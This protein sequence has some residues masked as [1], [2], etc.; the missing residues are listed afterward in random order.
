MAEREAAEKAAKEK[1]AK[2]A[3]AEKA[4]AVKA[5]AETAAAETLAAETAA[6]ETAAAEKAAAEKA[7]AEKAVAGLEKTDAAAA[8]QEANIIDEAPGTTYAIGRFNFTDMWFVVTELKRLD[9]GPLKPGI[10]VKFV[11]RLDGTKLSAVLPSPRCDWVFETTSA[12]PK[13]ENA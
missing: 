5:A 7:A 13:D 2:A 12:K 10:K 3:A 11:S 1:A 6:A 4:A 9:R 8:S